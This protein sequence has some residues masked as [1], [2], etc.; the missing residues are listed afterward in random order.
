MVERDGNV[1]AAP[2]PN[3]KKKTLQGAIERNVEPDSI[4]ITDEFKSYDGA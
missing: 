4:M 3:V 1:L 2:V